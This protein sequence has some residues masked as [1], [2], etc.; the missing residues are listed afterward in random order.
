MSPSAYTK[1]SGPYF[2]KV[3]D[4]YELAQQIQKWGRNKSLHLTK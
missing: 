1:N 3:N 4:A 2:I